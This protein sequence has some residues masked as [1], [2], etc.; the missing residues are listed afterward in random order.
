MKL[1]TE[2]LNMCII[3]R[4]HETALVSLNPPM[5]SQFSC[6]SYARWRKTCAALCHAYRQWPMANGKWQM[7]RDFRRIMEK[8]CPSAKLIK[9]TRPSTPSYDHIHSL[10]ALLLEKDRCL[11]ERV[12]RISV[13]TPASSWTSF[14]LKSKCYSTLG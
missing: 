5:P 8:Y 1:T 9:T 2:R 3:L 10:N 7:D 14:P 13:K 12:K 11:N 6:A 4:N